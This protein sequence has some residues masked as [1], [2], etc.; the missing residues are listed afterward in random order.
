MKCFR[1]NSLRKMWTLEY[2]AGLVP[3]HPMAV[4]ML[5]SPKHCTS[6]QKQTFILHFYH[7]DFD[8]AEKRTF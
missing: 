7:S 3:E 4:K 5:T 8:N 1:I 2:I 6:M